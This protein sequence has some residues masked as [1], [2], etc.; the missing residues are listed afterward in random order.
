MCLVPG[1]HD[2]NREQV[3]D[4]SARS[5]LELLKSEELL[6][7][8]FF[9]EKRY[10]GHR[11]EAFRRLRPFAEFYSAFLGRRLIDQPEGVLSL[12]YS[13]RVFGK[14]DGF[15]CTVDVAPI[16]TSWLCQS[17]YWAFRKDTAFIAGDYSEPEGSV[18]VCVPKIEEAFFA[19]QAAS[20]EGLQIALM[21]H[22]F[23][24]LVAS[25]RQAARNLICQQSDL[26]LT[27]HIHRSEIY[28]RRKNRPL[29]SS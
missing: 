13:P 21:H 17:Y 24:W 22:P 2:A 6:V 11:E 9:D 12:L 27:G 28:K 10:R 15:A 5:E 1:N 8:F 29:A 4:W 18:A 23:E 20:R 7:A 3:N 25:E 19:R 14:N 16:C 26:V